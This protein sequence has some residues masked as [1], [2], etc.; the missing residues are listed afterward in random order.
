MRT[1]CAA[2]LMLT[3]FTAIE[4]CSTVMVDEGPALNTVALLDRDL[5]NKII[6]TS[7]NARRSPTGT[8][9]AWTMLKNRTQSP[10]QLEGRVHFYDKSK[11]LLEGPTAWQRIMLAPSSLATYREFSTNVMDVGYYYIEIREAR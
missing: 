8:V 2:L 5:E 3:V 6:V 9:E 7:T 1:I 11:A 10:L 4:S